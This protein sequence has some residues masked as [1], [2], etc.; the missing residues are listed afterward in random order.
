MPFGEYSDDHQQDA[1]VDL[2][3]RD[4]LLHHVLRQPRLG[5]RHAVLREHVRR[6]EVHADLEGDVEQ[7]AAVARVERLHVDQVVDAVHLLL[8]RRRDRLLDHLGAR[9]GVGASRRGSI[10]GASGGYCST[11]RLRQRDRAGDHDQDA[12]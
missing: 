1:G 2:L 11:G 12:R 4:A 8:D 6:V 7:H 10:G 5:L 9:A 3:D